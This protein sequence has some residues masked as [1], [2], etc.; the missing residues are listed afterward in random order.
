MLQF[1]SKLA[2]SQHPLHPAVKSRMHCFLHICFTVQHISQ[3]TKL[4]YFLQHASIYYQPGTLIVSIFPLSC[5]FWTYKVLRPLE[6][7][8]TW[9]SFIW[10]NY[11]LHSVCSHPSSTASTW[12]SS[13][14]NPLSSSLF[15]VTIFIFSPLCSI[16]SF[17]LL[18]MSLPSFY[19][20]INTKSSA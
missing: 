6:I 3:V 12:Q 14:L 2:I 9:A 8:Q 16:P 7:S 15:P 13:W 4:Y 10:H 17:H 19:S 5:T 20:A 1:T 18:N 11:L